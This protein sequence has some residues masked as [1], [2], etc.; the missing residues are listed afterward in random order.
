MTTNPGDTQKESQKPITS[1][2]DLIV[3]YP[4]CFQGIGRFPGE[5]HIVID[6]TQVPV[7]HA[8]RKCPIKL[9]D[10]I[11]MELDEMESIGVIKKVNEP[12][13]WVNSAAYS[14]KIKWPFAHLPRSKGLEPCNQEKSPC[15]PNIRGIDAHI[16]REYNLL[17][18]RCATW[19]LVSSPRRRI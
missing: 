12:T 9:R 11:K 5:Y 8:P 1:K 18:G 19:V 14:K 17:K 10:D 6:P 4:D 3:M 2:E 15:H 13:D 7:V 16:R